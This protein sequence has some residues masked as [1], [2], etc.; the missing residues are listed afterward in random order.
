MDI[1]LVSMLNNDTNY[2]NNY[3]IDLDIKPPTDLDTTA[4]SFQI[5]VIERI[6]NQHQINFAHE[7][8]GKPETMF[9]RKH[10]IIRK[11]IKQLTRVIS[12]ISSGDIKKLAIFK[13][14]LFRR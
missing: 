12:L 2:E 7:Y 1:V 4:L 8:Q 9:L 10:G 14:L 3:K 6:L 5:V 13:H 11:K